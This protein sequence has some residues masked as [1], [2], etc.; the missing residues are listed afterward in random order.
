MITVITSTIR[1]ASVEGSR[2][3][4]PVKARDTRRDS[5]TDHNHLSIYSRQTS[6]GY[7]NHYIENLRAFGKKCDNLRVPEMQNTTIAFA[8]PKNKQKRV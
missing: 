5:Q 2:E 8:S 1:Y 3:M 6:E 7:S 4:E